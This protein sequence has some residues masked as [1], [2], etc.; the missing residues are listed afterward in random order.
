MIWFHA[1][2]HFNEIHLTS[3]SS[4]S[5]D[6]GGSNRSTV[7]VSSGKSELT[8]IDVHQPAQ[9]TLL[10]TYGS[11]HDGLGTWGASVYASRVYLSFICSV[12]PFR[13]TWT[14]VKILEI[15]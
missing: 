2:S 9:P 15:T 1:N 10:T 6:A 8:V 5:T 4:N 11:L 3:I 12:I 14:G 13:S 7:F